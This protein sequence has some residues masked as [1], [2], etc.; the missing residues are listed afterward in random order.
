MTSL[1]SQL[2]GAAIQMSARPAQPRHQISH[3]FKG[4]GTKL[5]IWITRVTQYFDSQKVSESERTALALDWLFDEIQATA[6]T[7]FEDVRSSTQLGFVPFAMLSE[8]LQ[9]IYYNAAD[10]DK[11]LDTLHPGLYKQRPDECCR[12]YFIRLKNDLASVK[13]NKADRYPNP[14]LRA[15]IFQ[16]GLRS[17]ELQQL[18]TWRGKIGD[19]AQGEIDDLDEA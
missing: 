4:D 2:A 10:I 19:K 6:R 9:K 17:I 14:S 18:S 13:H 16:K 11:L 5:A 3:T 12:E 15:L 1:T 7:W 8:Y